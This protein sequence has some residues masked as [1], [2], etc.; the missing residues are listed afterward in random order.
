[1]NQPAHGGT[2]SNPLV[3]RDLATFE[4]KPPFGI[5]PHL[6]AQSVGNQIHSLAW[7]IDLPFMPPCEAAEF[8]YETQR[9]V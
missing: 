8:L 5:T 1:M 9:E 2:R 3:T 4:S 7:G 6:K